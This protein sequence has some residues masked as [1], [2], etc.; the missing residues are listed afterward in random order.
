M[1]IHCQSACDAAISASSAKAAPVAVR[2]WIAAALR[3]RRQT[4]R[5]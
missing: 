4:V 3:R 1:N 5:S 2:K